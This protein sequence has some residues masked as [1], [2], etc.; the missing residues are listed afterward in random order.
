[1]MEEEE[2]IERESVEAGVEPTI[3]EVEVEGA[4][5]APRCLKQSYGSARAPNAYV[6]MEFQLVSHFNGHLILKNFRIDPS[7]LDEALAST[8]QLLS[9]LHQP[10]RELTAVNWESPYLAMLRQDLATDQTH[11]GKITPNNF[12][13][14]AQWHPM[15]SAKNVMKCRLHVPSGRFAVS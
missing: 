8:G 3:F 2:D 9:T 12:F 13:M 7:S 10:G 4:T 15:F 6:A 5:N 11:I 1:M 14:R